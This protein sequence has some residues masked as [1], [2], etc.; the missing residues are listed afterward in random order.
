MKRID[1]PGLL[2]A[3]LGQLRLAPE[4]FW[5]LTPVELVILL[6]LEGAQPPLTRS[7]LE[8]LAAA[9]PDLRKEAADGRS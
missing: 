7:R 1:W 5:R 6:G 8:A 2:R 3:G 9:F 4:A